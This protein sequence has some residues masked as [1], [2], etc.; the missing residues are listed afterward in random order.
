[1]TTL[2]PPFRAQT[3]NGLYKKVIKGAYPEIPKKYTK[4]LANIIM[5]MLSVDAKDRPSCEAILKMHAIK[6]RV[7]KLFPTEPMDSDFI[8][9]EETERN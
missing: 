4:D 2:K 1:M 9:E 7:Q 5:K 8:I 6:S 3:M